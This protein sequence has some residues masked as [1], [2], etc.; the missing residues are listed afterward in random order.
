MQPSETASKINPRPFFL[1]VATLLL[2]QLLGSYFAGQILRFDSFMGLWVLLRLVLPFGLV[3]L[4]G[5]PLSKLYFGKPRF[6]KQSL[7]I[8]SLAG[9][10]LAGLF[11]YLNWFGEDYLAYY[12]HGQS[13]EQLQAMGRFQSFM[14]FTAS[15]LVGWEILH[16]SFLLGGIQYSLHRFMQVPERSAM[17]IAIMTV[18]VF[19]AMFHIKKP[20]YE[21][22]PMVFASL[23]LSWLTIKTRS[24]W[25]ALTIHLGIEVIFGYAAFV[26]V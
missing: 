21:S 25:P 15:T 16:R 17:F 1:L 13:L 24:V 6:D 10:A 22:I 2:F 23:L 8:V 14:I 3:L 20:I 11:V 26:G 7:W 19:E 4:L 5:I 12:R 9:L 18:A